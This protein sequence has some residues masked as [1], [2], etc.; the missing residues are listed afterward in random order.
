MAE[1]QSRDVTFQTLL[2]TKKRP[3]NFCVLILEATPVKIDVHTSE[4][5]AGP[6]TAFFAHSQSP[7]MA[8]PATSRDGL[9][10]AHRAPFPGKAVAY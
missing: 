4:N 9:E 8:R 7:C 6:L 3:R 1:R 5:E 10:G 2:V